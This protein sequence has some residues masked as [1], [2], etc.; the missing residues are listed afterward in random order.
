MLGIL[1]VI[2]WTSGGVLFGYPYGSYPLVKNIEDKIYEIVWESASDS[3]SC[4]QGGRKST[5]CIRK[6]R[7]RLKGV[8][9][10]KRMI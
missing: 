8:L 7:K 1:A 10:L 3:G 5:V 4:F 2:L 9:I 6:C